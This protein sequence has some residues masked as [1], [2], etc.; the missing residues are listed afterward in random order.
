[1]K[2]KRYIL[3]SF[4][5]LC[6]AV[7]SMGAVSLTDVFKEVSELKGFTTEPVSVGDY[8]FP[9]DLG[10]ADITGYGN[11]EPREA[12]LKILDKLP[13]EL[14]IVEQKDEDDRI[15]RYYYQPSTDT[16]EAA[17]MYFFVGHSGNDTMLMLF[18]GAD[19]E[20]YADFAEQ[21]K[22]LSEEE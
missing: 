21:L 22:E 2:L 15:Q 19:S 18:T 1:M 5:A 9:S 3:L 17:L 8:G 7:T 4:M 10:F 12:V 6:S 11:S 20:V 13:P 14:L 16:S